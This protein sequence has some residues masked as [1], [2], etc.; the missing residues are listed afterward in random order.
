MPST[1]GNSLLDKLLPLVDQLRGTL[2]PAFGVRQYG[3]KLVKRTWSGV[4]RGDG[5]FSDVEVAMTP[6]PF[7]EIGA[8]PGWRYDLRPQGREE[9]GMLKVTE[10][11]MVNYQEDD[12]TGGNALPSTVQF[13]WLLKDAHGQG[14]RSRAYVPACPPTADRDKTLGWV[15][16]LRRAEGVDPGPTW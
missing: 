15:V 1:L 8:P 4:E 2:L 9:D 7:V 12:L 10:I 6:P 5:D 3:I 13:F 11:S 14:V 16:Y